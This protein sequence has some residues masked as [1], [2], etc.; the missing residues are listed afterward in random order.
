MV[1]EGR[2]GWFQNLANGPFET[3][4]FVDDTFG[5][6]QPDNAH[7]SGVILRLNDDG[8]TPVD[9]PFFAVGG[10][11][12]ARWGRTSGRSSPMAIGMASRWRSRGIY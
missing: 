1:D 4:P 12:G 6:P 2:R 9:N 5:G 8:S 7:L 3:A 10:A 11:M